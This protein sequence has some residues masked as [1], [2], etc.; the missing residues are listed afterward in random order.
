MVNDEEQ[1]EVDWIVKHRRSNNGC[2][3]FLV[4]WK[5]YPIEDQTWE[6][7]SNLKDAPEILKAYKKMHKWQ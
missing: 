3:S 7:A 1:Y 4:H 6:P 2:L 5:G